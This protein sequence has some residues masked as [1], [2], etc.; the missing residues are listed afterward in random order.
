M[1]RTNPYTT[2]KNEFSEWV[3]RAINRRRI[4][5]WVCPRKD[6]SEPWS[7]YDLHQR[8][9][10]AQQLGYEVHLRSSDT[11]LHVEY[12]QKLPERPWNI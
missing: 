10:A 4:P 9:L 6:L 1:K 5:M 12:V 8:A 3:S 2:L 7:L 11:G